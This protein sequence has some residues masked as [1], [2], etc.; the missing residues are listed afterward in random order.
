MNYPCTKCGAC[1]RLIYT[2]PLFDQDMQEDDGSCKYL[3]NNQCSIYEKRPEYCNIILMYEKYY[4]QD[5]NIDEFYS[6]NIKVCNEL[7][8]ML[9][10][11]TK[12]RIVPVKEL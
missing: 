5:Y 12:F 3:I 11:D 8:D 7:Q 10:I 6:L 4:K 9:G 1:C 2:S